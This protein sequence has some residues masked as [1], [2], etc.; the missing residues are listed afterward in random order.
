[1]SEDPIGFEG[2][3]INLYRYASNILLSTSDPVGLF[4][5]TCHCSGWLSTHDYDVASSWC[6]GRLAL[7][8]CSDVCNTYGYG[9]S[10]GFDVKGTVSDEISP[11]R[12]AISAV[13][14]IFNCV[15]QFE[16]WMLRLTIDASAAGACAALA[17]ND[18][19][20]VTNT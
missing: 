20:T 6:G 10:S 13:G 2:N 3:D 19:A 9:S 15:T 5:I 18:Y 16:A 14:N 11:F 17:V 1:V 7:N 12:E 8:C 4:L